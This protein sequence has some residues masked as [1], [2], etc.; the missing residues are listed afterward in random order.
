MNIH[1]LLTST[2]EI[3]V[4]RGGARPLSSHVDALRAAGSR[5]RRHDVRYFYV[6]SGSDVCEEASEYLALGVGGSVLGTACPCSRGSHTRAYVLAS[7]A[8]AYL[9][10]ARVQLRVWTGPRTSSHWHACGRPAKD[11]ESKRTEGST[12]KRTRW[13]SC[14]VRPRALITRPARAPLLALRS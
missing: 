4:L 6:E 9:P 5:A 3:A 10:P 1:A 11:V 13:E 7:C 14:E 8:R 12:T 2:L